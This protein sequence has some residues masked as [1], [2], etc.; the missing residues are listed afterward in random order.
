MKQSE[1]INNTLINRFNLSNTQITTL[2]NMVD[3]YLRWNKKHNL[4][5]K[6]DEDIIWERHVFDSLEATHNIKDFQ[7]N[8]QWLDMGSGMGF[9]LIPLT[10]KHPD[11]TFHSIE[12]R[13]KRV[14]I[15]KQF[16]RDLK[17]ENLSLNCGKAE[18]FVSRETL[19]IFD[20]VSCRALG[21]LKEDWERSEEFLKTGGKFITFKTHSEIDVFKQTPW[22]S[23]E[24]NFLLKNEPYYI[25]V[26]NK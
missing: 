14:R 13:E 23:Y 9:P 6:S 24:Y 17:I 3:L 2:Y 26:R 22:E 5:S 18:D 7:P 25:V 12:P 1:T 11:I 16:K 8:N 10:I 4:I 15:L 19:H 20:F 21:S